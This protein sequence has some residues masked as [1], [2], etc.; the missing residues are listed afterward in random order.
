MNYISRK[1]AAELIGVS[2]KTIDRMLR[3]GRING[4]KPFGSTRVLIYSSSLKKENLVSPKPIY[5]N[6]F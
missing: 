2:T 1:Q 6:N 4:F 5:Q 3:D